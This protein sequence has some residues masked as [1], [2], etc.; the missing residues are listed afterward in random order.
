MILVTPQHQLKRL[1]NLTRRRSVIF[2]IALLLIA[3][4]GVASQIIT[5]KPKLDTRPPHQNFSPRAISRGP[6]RIAAIME[7]S[8]LKPI[9]SPSVRGGDRGGLRHDMSATI[10]NPPHSDNETCAIS[11]A[12]RR[13]LIGTSS[14]QSKPG[15]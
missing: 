15:P 2:S 1:S 4:Y 14:A 8:D 10:Q 5:G 6:A 3:H 11:K 13:N 12:Y 9:E 7:L